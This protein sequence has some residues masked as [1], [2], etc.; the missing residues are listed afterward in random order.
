MYGLFDTDLLRMACVWEGDHIEMVSM[1]PLTYNVANQYGKQPGGM[2]ALAGIVGEPISMAGFSSRGN[3]AVALAGTTLAV[4]NVDNPHPEINWGTLFGKVHYDNHDEAKFIW[5]SSGTHEPKF[6]LVPVL[7]GSFKATIYAMLFAVPL[8]LFGAIYVSHFTTPAFK[9][10]IKPVAEIMAAVPSVVVGFL[11]LLWLAPKFGDWIVAVFASCLTIPLTFII[12]MFLWQFA[13]RIS[14]VKRVENGYEFLVAAVFVI[15][16]GAFLAYLLANPLES[17]FFDGDFRQ[18]L[19][20]VFD[21]PYEQLNSI[22]VAFGLG[23]AVIPI[24]F[25]ISEDALSS[26]PGSLTAASLAV[27][28]SRWQTAWRVV[29][30]S[31]SPAIFAAV[32]IGFGRAVGETMIVFMA[33]GNTPILDGSPLNG[34]R[35][36]SANIAVEI[37][38]APVDGTLYR[39]LF[40]C[41]VLLFLLTF[42]LNA[43]AEVVRQRLRKKYGQY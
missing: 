18:W 6:S 41:A 34:F 17:L 39:V 1:A 27:G 30:P 32:M 2:G 16:P 12:F 38:E 10:A 28:A 9:K 24:I 4:W 22:V 37:G 11:V 26:I 36:L 14:W 43:V 23:F 21:S 33:T 42:V 13:R 7:F 31:A 40:L 20:A 25:S 15:L 5:Q 35:T 29:L 8:A 3:A 19:A